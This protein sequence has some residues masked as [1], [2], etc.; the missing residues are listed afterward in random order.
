MKNFDLDHKK[1][2]RRDL[3]KASVLLAASAS[4]LSLA[5]PRRGGILRVAF[6]GI[7][8]LD[9]YKTGGNN[10]ESNA[11]SLIF[12]PLFYLS[13]DNFEPSPCLAEKWST[14]DDTTWV[15]TLRKGVKFQDDNPVFA[16][17]QGREV[18]ADDVVYS[19]D[20][21]VKTANA[22]PLGTLKSVR[23]VDKYTV[24][25][26][27]AAPDPFFLID[28]NRL[29]RVHIVPREAIEK[30]GDDGFAQNPIG[31]GAFKLKSFTPNQ[32]LG[33]ERNEDYWIPVNLDGV[34]FVYLPDP[35][36]AA[37][38]LQGGRIDVIPYLFNIDS[39]RQLS[40]NPNLKLLGRGGSYR[41][42]GFN[43]KT[44]PFDS[45]LVRD[46][47]A[48]A[49]D[50][51]SAV[52]AVV[53][54]YGR[55]AYGQVPPWVPF[56]YDPSLKDLWT[57]DPKAALAGLAKAGYNKRNKDG[58]LMKDGQP[59][60]FS[61]KV[62]PGSQVRVLT[63]LV[64]QMKLLGIDAKIQQ[65][66]V[67]VWAS[68]LV[69]GKDTGMFFDFS[70]AGITGLYSL[71]AGENIGT[72][73]THQYS[74]PEVNALFAE[75]LKTLDPAK[76]STLWKQAQRII[77]RDKVAIPL[78]FEEGFSVVNKRVNDWVP[79]WGPLRVVSPENNV[80]LG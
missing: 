26:K 6:S 22:F 46:S 7:R 39:A 58:I 14:P 56:G 60:S 36:V 8:Q 21:Y 41:G 2:G 32:S 75:A 31:T 73:N 24:E 66:D 55:R 28:P 37:L 35:T 16:R 51:D 9:P 76:R 68:D 69:N 5:Q 12:D 70:Y 45:Q 33:F 43:V 19:L 74:N 77:M 71:F 29:A 54:P 1:I 23:A 20:R 64:T 49:L 80:Y 15:F 72:S 53:A 47:I 67:S 10:A 48:K 17:G 4:G 62:I 79:E 40:K 38:A 57:Y 65:Q 61:I 13:K 44:P 3:L 30:L 59:L 11:V 52:Q 78:Y 42:L 50:I 34:Q 27:K 25:I 18:V 63:I